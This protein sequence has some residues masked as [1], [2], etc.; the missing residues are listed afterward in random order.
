MEEITDVDYEHAKNVF[1][2]FINKNIGDYH[3]LY[4][5][6]ETLLFADVFEDFRNKCIEIYGDYHDL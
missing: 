2:T 4:V 1:K 5:Q 6:N 3:D